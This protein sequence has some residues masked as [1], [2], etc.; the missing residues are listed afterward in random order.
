MLDTRGWT[1]T[2]AAAGVL[3]VGGLG[4]A[5]AQEAGQE[6]AGLDV[7]ALVQQM[8]LDQEARADLAKLDDL[9]RRRAAMRQGMTDLRS[10]MHGTVREL[11]STLTAEQF[12]QLHRAMRSSMRMGPPGG[13]GLMGER[14]MMRGHGPR[15]GMGGMMRGHRGSG[16][17]GPGRG[18]ERGPGAGMRAGECPH[19]QPGDD[20]EDGSS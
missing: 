2:L 8:E 4:A 10:E 18:M 3:L 1:T 6:S 9:L 13:S 12:G 5:I 17:A 11:R 7:E 14:G 20:A 16:H 15:A 19:L